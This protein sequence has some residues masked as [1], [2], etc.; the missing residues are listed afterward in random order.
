MQLLS[1]THKMLTQFHPSSQLH[2]AILDDINLLLNNRV[3][4]ALLLLIRW[5][6]NRNQQ[7]QLA[8][9]GHVLGSR[10][11]P[12][13]DEET[14]AGR[15]YL[16]KVTI[17]KEQH[18]NMNPEIPEILI[19]SEISSA[20]SKGLSNGIHKESPLVL[21]GWDSQHGWQRPP[22]RS[23]PCQSAFPAAQRGHPSKA[24]EQAALS[25]VRAPKSPSCQ[26][27]IFTLHFTSSP[28]FENV[29]KPFVSEEAQLSD[30]SHANSGSNHPI[31]V[32]WKD[33]TSTKNPLYSTP[34]T[35]DS[36]LAGHHNYLF[37]HTIILSYSNRIWG[38]VSKTILRL[39]DSLGLTGLR[40]CSSYND[41]SLQ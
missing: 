8:F 27:Y 17:G 32:K 24:D 39:D 16:P 1:S 30:S 9:P 34:K 21:E 2:K 35:P 36:P 37:S 18:Q 33:P 11:C 22:F 15:S 14:R 31:R 28:S 5:T 41:S 10:P 19:N 40:S 3:R 12:G 7:Q 13:T 4:M 25:R 6:Q 29:D 20:D 38:A 26:L 23:L